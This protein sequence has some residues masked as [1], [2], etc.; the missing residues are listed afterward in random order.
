MVKINY[1]SK[2]IIKKWLEEIDGVDLS[3]KPKKKEQNDD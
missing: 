3:Y 1:K 2:L